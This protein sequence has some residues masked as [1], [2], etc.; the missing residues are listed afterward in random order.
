MICDGIVVNVI[1]PNMINIIT[2]VEFGRG[3]HLMKCLF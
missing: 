2:T 3:G 1:L